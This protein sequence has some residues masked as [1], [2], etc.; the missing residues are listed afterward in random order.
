MQN[1]NLT[2]YEV[3]ELIVRLKTPQPSLRVL[4]YWDQDWDFANV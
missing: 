1:K 4:K 3:F 2:P